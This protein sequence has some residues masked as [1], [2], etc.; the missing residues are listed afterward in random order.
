[1][2]HAVDE[3]GGTER[4][5]PTLFGDQPAAGRA[6]DFGEQIEFIGTICER[7]QC[8]FAQPRTCHEPDGAP[9]SLADQ[10]QR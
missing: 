5:E 3:L 6:F 8:C 1:M 10:R 4:S 7:S 9:K 2:G